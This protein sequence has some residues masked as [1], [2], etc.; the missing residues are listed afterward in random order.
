MSA[1]KRILE[2]PWVIAAVAVGLVIVAIL[3][4]WT[5]RAETQGRYA[6]MAEAKDHQS[7]TA[8]LS[9]LME[10][11]DGEEGEV[12]LASSRT[13][14]FR[15]PRGARDPFDASLPDA[16]THVPERVETWRCDAV[17]LRGVDPIALVNGV[18]CRV[19]EKLSGAKVI[20]IDR[21]GVTLLNDGKELRLA[22]TDPE[23]DMEIAVVMVETE[24][25]SVT[26]VRPEGLSDHGGKR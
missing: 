23:A 3:N 24:E 25:S 1:V 5:F 10:A 13:G 16:S 15:W 19:G 6:M 20:A 18:P 7:G 4:L 11:V 8:T 12:A 26:A 14:D 9:F 2:R 21:E 17:V 22:V